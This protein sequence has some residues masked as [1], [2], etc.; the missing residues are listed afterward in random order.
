M[1]NII[2]KLLIILFITSCI[3][4][5]NIEKEVIVKAESNEVFRNAYYDDS[6]LEECSLDEI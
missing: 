3:S 5:L 6:T 2:L 4:F 1:K